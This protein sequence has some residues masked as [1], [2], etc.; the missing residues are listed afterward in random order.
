MDRVYIET[1]GC[2]ANKSD[3][4]IM[5][6]VLREAGYLMSDLNEADYLVVN[7]CGVKQATENKIIDRL[8]KLSGLNKKLI[9]AG[10]LTKI[11][12]N[13]IKKEIPNF[14]ALV[15]PKSI[16]EIANIIDRVRNN[17][18][19]II[20][21]SEIPEEKPSLPRF[22][23]SSGIDIIR[24]SEGCLSRCSFCSTKLARGDLHSYR[25]EI[26]RNAV[27]QGLKNGHKEFHLASEDSS[28]YGRDIGTNLPELLESV[29]KI[30]G[31]FFIRVGMMNPLHFKKVEIRNLIKAYKHE[32]V[33]KFLHLCVQSGSNKIL[34]DM[35]R[36]YSVEEFI[37]YVRHFREEIPELTLSTD[38]I[39]G[40][41]SE[42]DSDFER[43]VDLLKKIRPDVVNLSKYSVRPGTLAAKMKN[44]DSKVVDKRS[45]EI[46]KLI[47]KIS[48]RNNEKWIG[49]KGKVLID[50]N[51]KGKT[52]ISRNYSYKPV[53][54][55]GFIG[56]FKD[57]KIVEAEDMHLVGE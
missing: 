4:E 45:N 19:Q 40:F 33:F 56:S 27:K 30:N 25:P 44:L 36:G 39:V 18:E 24:L 10:C 12:M 54:T 20:Q 53:V 41:P 29:A 35:R 11:N 14:S 23:F 1:Y 28:A 21:F 37:D 47:R 9:V 26:I 38:I 50:E 3:S 16:H 55:S 7:T 51:G 34:R 6:G 57:V 31:D 49:W 5:I 43:T 32:K 22:S 15:D 52:V 2:T 17:S 13:R 48:R 46:H 42:T 8:K